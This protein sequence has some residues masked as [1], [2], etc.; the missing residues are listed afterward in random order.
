MCPPRGGVASGFCDV[1][2]LNKKDWTLATGPPL[3]IVP[4]INALSQ[5]AGSG[6]AW[7]VSSVGIPFCLPAVITMSSFCSTGVK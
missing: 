3:I 4:E 6:A 5:E 1:G 7:N 2:F